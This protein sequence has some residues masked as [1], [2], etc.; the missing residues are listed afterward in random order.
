MSDKKKRRYR[1]SAHSGRPIENYGDRAYPFVVDLEGLNIGKQDKPTLLDHNLDLE[2]GRTEKIWIDPKEG[3]KAEGYFNETSHAQYVMDLQ[4]QGVK[5]QASV[6]F[7]IDRKH[8]EELAEGETATVNG[9]SVEG[10]M[11]IY[12]K[13][14]L[15]EV[16]FTTLGADEYTEAVALRLSQNNNEALVMSAEVEINM[17]DDQ[18]ENVDEVEVSAEEVTS[19]TTENTEVEL[20]AYTDETPEEK[21]EEETE[22]AAEEAP[23]EDAPE[24][25]ADV[26]EGTTD[27]EEITGE[28]ETEVQAEEEVTEEEPKEE[29]AVEEADEDETVELS[30]VDNSEELARIAN[31]IKLALPGQEDVA[32]DLILNNT[33]TESEIKLAFFEDLNHKN[34]LQL[35]DLADSAA[36]P[37]SASD[38]APEPEETIENIDPVQSEW[39]ADPELQAE[40][41]DI[42][43]YQRYM[44]IQERHK[45]N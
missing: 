13:T 20:G 10:P 27:A 35:N 5:H 37:S 26:E 45:R 28:D 12:R 43:N 42:S 40:F 15:R 25:D 9:M 32:A 2:I 21:K 23:E 17:N 36:E 22:I 8:T 16:T 6:L 31:I 29:E 4:D 7:P 39:D 1:M 34:S 44:A 41:G 30:A 11:T 18:I 24:A 38:V 19:E 14:S 3:R 33:S